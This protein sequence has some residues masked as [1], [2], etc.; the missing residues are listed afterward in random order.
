MR[1]IERIL[2]PTDFSANARLAV[3]EAVSLASQLGAQVH[4]L[5]V[6]SRSYIRQAIK[7]GI[8]DPG[9]TDESIQARTLE[10]TKKRLAE[11]VM[12]CGCD[13]VDIDTY[14]REG[15]AGVEIIRFAL[16]LPADLIVLGNYGIGGI[17]NGLFGSAAEKIVRKASIPVLLIRAAEHS[18]GA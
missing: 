1:K 3:E 12:H 17:R 11:L 16:E 6:N 14:I 10:L 4:V 9:D 13:G 5:T 7:E 18:N 15:D 8:L 2:A